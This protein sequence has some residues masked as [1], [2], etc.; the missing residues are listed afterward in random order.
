MDIPQAVAID[1]NDDAL[2]AGRTFS[3]DFE[4]RNNASRRGGTDAFVVKVLN[5]PERAPI[6]SVAASC[7]TGGPIRVGWS[8]ATPAAPIGIVFARST[9]SVRI[10]P[11]NPCAGTE[12]GLST[13]QLRLVYQGTAGPEGSRTLISTVG[14]GACGAYLQLLDIA[15]CNLSNVARIE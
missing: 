6:L 3:T 1:G 12:L 7:P 13:D 2:I 11:G 5:D 8:Q 15:R 14:P 4:G 9:G 10:P